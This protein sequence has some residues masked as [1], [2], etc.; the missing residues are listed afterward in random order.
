MVAKPPPY[1]EMM[2]AAPVTKRGMEL[3]WAVAVRGRKKK[4]RG[5]RVKKA[6]KV[7]LRPRKSEVEAQKKRPAMLRMESRP[8]KPTAAAGPAWPRKRS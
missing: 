3:R 6:K 4:S 7:A 2:M 8:T 5:P 1:M